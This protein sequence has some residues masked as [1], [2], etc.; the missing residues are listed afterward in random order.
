VS[1]TNCPNWAVHLVRLW[2]VNDWQVG[3]W[4][5]KEE[6]FVDVYGRGSFNDYT[7][8]RY[9]RAAFEPEDGLVSFAWAADVRSWMFG[10]KMYIAILDL[11][12]GNKLRCLLSFPT[13]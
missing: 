11:D 13:G 8:S 6:P 4:R 5:V 2:P 10:Q 12:E 1:N 3:F 7:S 9:A